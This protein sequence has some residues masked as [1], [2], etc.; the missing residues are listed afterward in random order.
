MNTNQSN[1]K[2][3]TRRD[4]LKGAS[5]AALLGGLSIERAAYGQSQ[6]DLLKVAVVGCGGRG[7]GAAAQ[8][9]KTAGNVK[10]VAMADAF[11]DRLAGS[12]RNIKENFKEAPERIAVTEDT[13]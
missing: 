2:D 10:L 9:V 7:T 5:T 13:Q 3:F 1:S 4:F 6:S 12:L 8:A 11:K